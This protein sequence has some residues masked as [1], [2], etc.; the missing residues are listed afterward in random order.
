MKKES[1]QK[2]KI[3]KFL[4]LYFILGHY[5]KI[6]YS[7]ILTDNLRQVL[8]TIEVLKNGGVEMALVCI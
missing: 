1:Q 8:K 2:F 6:K 7:L 3:L 5:F 4:K